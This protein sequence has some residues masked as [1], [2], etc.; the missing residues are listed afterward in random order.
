MTGRRDPSNAER[1]KWHRRRQRAGRSAFV[2][3]CADDFIETLIERGAISEK[4]A[5]DKHLLAERLGN[6]IEA[7]LIS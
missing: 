4:E 2:I 5:S 1:Q 7:A 6:L 3:Y